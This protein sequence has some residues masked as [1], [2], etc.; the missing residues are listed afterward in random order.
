MGWTEKMYSFTPGAA[1]STT[2]SFTSTTDGKCGPA[3]DRVVIME[4]LPKADNCKK[5]GWETM[6]DKLGNPFKNQ[7]DCVSYYA[8]GEKNL[9]FTKDNE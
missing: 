6:V 9:A 4:T 2:I 7:G 8:T 5:G 3:L 1:G